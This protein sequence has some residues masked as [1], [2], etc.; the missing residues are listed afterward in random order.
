[1]DR[2]EVPNGQMNQTFLENLA[3]TF[4]EF[5]DY[6]ID[7]H[8]HP[9]V[10][11]NAFFWERGKIRFVPSTTYENLHR[12]IYIAYC[13]IEVKFIPDHKFEENM[14]GV[15]GHGRKLIGNSG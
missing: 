9:E 4:Y 1:M 3:D 15:V 8:A 13:G 10:F 12:A 2:Y 6:R 5:G 14:V 11:K 7:V